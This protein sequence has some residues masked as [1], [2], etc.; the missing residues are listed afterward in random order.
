MHVALQ[1]LLMTAGGALAGGA[2]RATVAG[3]VV[4]ALVGFA[5]HLVG[6]FI[7]EGGHVSDGES[8]ET[9]SE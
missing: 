4:G 9:M 6:G 7:R 5:L 2:W 8:R 3:S 1:C